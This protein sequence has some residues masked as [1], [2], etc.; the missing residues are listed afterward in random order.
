MRN[1]LY[2]KLKLSPK[3]LLLWLL[4]IALLITMLTACSPCKQYAKKCGPVL[5]SK[6]DTVTN[7]RVEKIT[8]MEKDTVY[9][10]ELPKE[11][12]N[13][14]G[15]LLEILTASTSYAIATAWVDTANMILNLQ[16]KNREAAKLPCKIIYKEI[17]V[18]DSTRNKSNKNEVIE[19]YKQTSWQKFMYVSGLVSWCIFLI[20]LVFCFIKLSVW[21]K[22]RIL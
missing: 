15:K 12:E 1:T 9:I 3:K 19:A 5:V 7:T 22:K 2:L 4:V 6:T 10:K 18:S 16:I 14:Y 11:N 20:F 8:V 21:I 13:I 17:Y